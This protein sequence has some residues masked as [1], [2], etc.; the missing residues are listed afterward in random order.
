MNNFELLSPAGNF[1]SLKMA[2]SAGCDAVYIGGKMFGARAFS[3]NFSDEEIVEAINYCHLRGVKVFVAVNTLI[4]DREVSKFIKYIEFLHVNSV[5]AVII[6]DIGMMDLIRKTFPNLEIHA[7]TQMH[8][9]NK[10][11]VKILKSLGVKRVVLA[12]ETNIDLISEIKKS[13]DMDLEV[14]VHGSLCISY[15]GQCLMSSL[16]GNRSGNRGSCAGTCR[17]NYETDD[18]SGYLLSAKDLC[19]LDN[20]GKL[21]DIGV[22]SFKIEGRMKSPLY[23]YFVTKLYRSAIDSYLKTGVVS[24]DIDD[25]NNLKKIF[26]RE[27]TKGFLFGENN[28][29]N[30]YRPNHLGVSIGKVVDYKNGFVYIKLSNT[31]N[32]NDGI[33]IMSYDDI[34]FNIS[35]MFI[36]GKKVVCAKNGD[37]IGI[38][39]TDEIKIGSAVV[40]TSDYILNKSI[41][42]I[43]DKK[44]G[45]NILIKAILGDDFIL[46]FNDGINEVLVKRNIVFKAFSKPV[47]KEQIIKQI[48]K[49]GDTVYFVD[50]I[51]CECSEDI[52]VNIKDLNEI[53]REA[54]ILLNEIRLYKSSFVK[55]DY[56]VSLPDF[57]KSNNYNI[58]IKNF[59][60]Y[61]MIK[62]YN[63]KQIYMDLDLYELVKDERKVLKLDRVLEKHLHYD[64]ELLVGEMG[65][66]L[67]ENINADFSFNVVNSY[68]VAFLHALGVL[69]VT[70]SLEMG[71]TQVS[72]LVSA[73]C[74]RYNKHPNLE[75]IVFGKEE[76]MISK[77]LI[78]KKYIIDRLGNKYPII[79]NNNL[80]TI[81][82]YKSSKINNVSDYFLVGVNNLRLNI[83]NE[84]DFMKYFLVGVY[85]S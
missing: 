15:S 51:C 33:R 31:V 1:L 58:Y 64:C 76:A 12:R 77:Y 70:L 57:E 72:E 73:Y 75:V 3:N 13:C 49:L 62:K 71:F 22:N 45:I 38:K 55:K 30:S 66:L 29:V 80:M 8:I 10:N 46:S 82:N 36:N 41:D 19:S 39:V 67:Y 56:E 37:V 44:I 74:E 11:G 28:I 53:R 81:Y 78:Y 26:N 16:I 14:F 40:K 50:S 65:S 48:S 25:L 23:V 32:L 9:H 42:N 27:Y 52:F 7:S 5:D 54:V 43:A 20:I 83:L 34:G 18:S 6:Q 4:Y 59:N 2:V 35:S 24:Y 60:Q 17:L 47:L 68:S 63:F 69:K 84:K 21:I 85:E 79:I 61:E